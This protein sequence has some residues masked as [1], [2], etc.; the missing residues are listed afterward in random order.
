[1]DAL[2][3][4]EDTARLFDQV[5]EI[6]RKERM[7]CESGCIVLT[8]ET[9]AGANTTP[10]LLIESDID[11]QAFDWSQNVSNYQHFEQGKIEER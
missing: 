9:G 2:K 5:D 7:V 11:M 8:F 4:P 6:V 3:S 10:I 1:V